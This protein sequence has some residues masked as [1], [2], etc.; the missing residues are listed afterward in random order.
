ME[1]EEPQIRGEDIVVFCRAI[2]DDM[3][4][5]PIISKKCKTKIPVVCCL[6]IGP[7]FRFFVVGALSYLLYSLLPAILYRVTFNLREKIWFIL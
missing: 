2:L 1:N 7:H 4:E 6:V 3:D 5:V